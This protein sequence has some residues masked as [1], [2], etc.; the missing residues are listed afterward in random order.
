MSSFNAKKLFRKVWARADADGSGELDADE[1]KLV[2]QAMG[3]KNP[4]MDAIMKEVDTDG[5][6]EVDKEEFEKW[7]AMRPSFPSEVLC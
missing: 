2:L 3:Q 5:S 1:L 7:C 4:D 6:G